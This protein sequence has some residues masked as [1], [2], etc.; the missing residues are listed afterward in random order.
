MKAI[1]YLLISILAIISTQL[2]AQNDVSIGHWRTHL[3]Y[4]NVKDVEI[5]G[6]KYYA[7]TPYE[8]F[9]YDIEDNSISILNKIKGLSDIGI[10]NIRYNK[11]V[12]ALLVAY[13]NA[14]IDLIKHDGDIINLREIKDHNIIGTKT[15]NNVCFDG[16]TAYI[17]CSF[18]IVV[19]NLERAEVKD[20]YYIGNNGS[21]VNINDIALFNDS[22]YAATENGIFKASLHENSLANFAVWQR[23]QSL[24]HPQLNY[25]EIES[26]CGKLYA[27]YSSTEFSQDTMFVYDG[28]HW[29][30]FMPSTTSNVKEIRNCGNKMTISRYYSVQVINTDGAEE[31]LIYQ[32]INSD[33]VKTITTTSATISSDGKTFWIGDSKRGA[34]L[35][36]D[37]WN[38]IDILPNCPHSKNVYEITA[39]GDNVSVATGGHSSTWANL[40]LQ[41]GVS[42][43]DGSWWE[44][45][46]SGTESTWSG[47]YDPVCN[48]IDPYDET[49]T[50]VGTWGFGVLKLKDGKVV[51][52]YNADN[53]SL[54]GLPSDASKVRISGLAFDQDGNLWVANSSTTNML[55]VMKRDG[56]W[57][58]FYLGSN[59]SNVDIANLM[60]DNN[61]YKWILKR[62]NGDG[63]VIVFNDNGTIDN[64]NDDQVRLLYN[65]AGNGGLNGSQA[66]SMATD[67]NGA[68]WIGTDSGPSVFYD[69]R[70]IFTSSSISASQILIDRNDGTGQADPLFDKIKVLSIAIDGANQK[71]F[72]LETGVYQMSADCKTV[73]AN[74][75]TDNSPLL[76]NE[77]NTMAISKSGEIF[78]GTNEGIISFRG[79][80]AEGSDENEDVKVYPNPVRADFDGYVGITGL[81]NNALVRITTVDG[82]FVTQLRAQGSQATWDLTNIS[83][84]PVKPGI[85]VVFSSLDDGKQKYSTKILVM[86]NGQ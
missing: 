45:Y 33:G 67:L 83:G 12:D 3:P 34:L 22:I 61:G 24:I 28:N 63:R 32:L 64:S 54:G 37:G 80:A 20:T 50:Y 26:F 23:D 5:F 43:F 15:I 77:V 27:N 8:L 30:Y 79:H 2:S 14:N 66:F 52:R 82:M 40:Y 58:S 18:G 74:F 47:L 60:I 65:T 25:N 71:W 7:A 16:S 56:T 42:R 75:N 59:N 70:T 62:N 38:S 4:H 78:F 84:E 72:G 81:A 9:Y 39:T 68:V 57:K 1:K 73:I 55:S 51:E 49:V 48:A 76:S 36:Y 86:K 21:Y 41:D 35:T 6:E 44:N 29:D 13:N 19:Y 46:Y 10:N 31:K 11:A 53:S 69:T 85:Y 17:A